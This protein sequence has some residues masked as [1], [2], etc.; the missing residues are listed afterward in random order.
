MQESVVIPMLIYKVTNPFLSKVSKKT[1]D[2]ILEQYKEMV[3][4]YQAMSFMKLDLS[5]KKR[6]GNYD[7]RI[8]EMER[9][10]KYQAQYPHTV[11]IYNK[12]LCK[13]IMYTSNNNS[14]AFVANNDAQPSSVTS[15]TSQPKP[16]STN[17]TSTFI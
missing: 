17:I 12:V 16:N 7:A 2:Y 3:T 14:G 10:S 4:K 5:E 11:F 6:L 8:V 1:R 13:M 9:I 15:A